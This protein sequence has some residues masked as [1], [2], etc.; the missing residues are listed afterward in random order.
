MTPEQLNALATDNT[1]FV[2]HSV[3]H[4]AGEISGH[5]TY[6]AGAPLP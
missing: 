2:V 5:I 1:Y 3:I 6:P 4:E